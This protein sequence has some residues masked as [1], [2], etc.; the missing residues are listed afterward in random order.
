MG[1]VDNEFLPG[2]PPGGGISHCP[3]ICDQH[4]QDVSVRAAA[5]CSYRKNCPHPPIFPS[6]TNIFKM[7]LS[8]LQQAAATG[9]TAHIHRA[10]H[11]VGALA[12]D[13]LS[14]HYT[15]AVESLRSNNPN[16]L[17]G[18]LRVKLTD[19]VERFSHIQSNNEEPPRCIKTD[20]EAITNAFNTVED[21]IVE[22]LGQLVGNS[23]LLVKENMEIKKTSQLETKTH[24]HTYI[25]KDTV[26]SEEITN[27]YSLPFH[28]DNG[29]WL[30]MTPAV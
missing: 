25:N 6:A 3:S 2:I 8:E 16:C 20:Y 5:G 18:A 4:L 22:V 13:G 27:P 23:S 10:L 11:N 9:R 28:Q 7:S 24:V 21:K 1:T 26:Q 30:L 29:L 17:K 12:V 19:G 14:A 15:Q